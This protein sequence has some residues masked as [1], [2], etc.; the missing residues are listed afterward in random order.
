M[1]YLIKLCN[2]LF[3]IVSLISSCTKI[4]VD[5]VEDVNKIL[6]PK[7]QNFGTMALL[8]DQQNLKK[9]IM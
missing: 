2:L 3:I 6:I 5:K 9:M 7:L 8:M 1:K 4:G